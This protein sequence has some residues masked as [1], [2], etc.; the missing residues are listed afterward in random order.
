MKTKRWFVDVMDELS[1][2]DPQIAQ[3]AALLRENEVVAFPTETVYGLGANAKSTD[4]VKKIY[5]AKGRPSDNPLIVHIADIS[6]L[7]GLTGPA[8]DKA[9]IL[10][11]RFWPG[12]LTLI[13]PCKPGALSPR[14]TAGLDTVAVRMPDHPLA[15][16][17]IRAA[18]LPI[19]APSANLSGKPSPTKAEHVAH[20]LDGRIAGMM[21]G[22]STGIGVESTVLSCAGETP[23]LLRPGGITKEQIEA[24]IGPI[25]VDKGIAD[26]NEQPISPGMKYTHYAPSAPLVISEGSPERIQTLI[27]EYQQAGKRVGVLT[28]EEN[29]DFYSA[30]YVKS[31]GRRDQLETVAAAL[32]DA[33]RSFDE[34]KVD[35]IIA[36]SFP[37]TGVGLAIM[38]RLMKAAGGRVIR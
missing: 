37:D 31:C 23:V 34:E 28:T 15:L 5:E 30:D 11:K 21:D 9:K 19:A 33:L 12:A 36:E 24:E 17:L 32:Y 29:A 26:Q 25:L 16:A 35:F 38:N 3:A 20:D 10:M 13:L 7:D 4:A 8:P 2:N 27:Q 1:T 18:G 6:Q 14:V 22:G